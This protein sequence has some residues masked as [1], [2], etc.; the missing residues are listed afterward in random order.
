MSNVTSHIL[1]KHVGSVVQLT[2][3]LVVPRRF[4]AKAMSVDLLGVDTRQIETLME[5]ETFFF[6]TLL[7]FADMNQSVWGWRYRHRCAFT[8]SG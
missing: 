3:G 5:R 4:V 6:A 2:V 8:Y 1:P 7:S